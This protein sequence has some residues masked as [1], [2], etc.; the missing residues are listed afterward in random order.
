[1]LR[2]ELSYEELM[3]K[4]STLFK[5]LKNKIGDK[6][7]RYYVDSKIGYIVFYTKHI[8]IDFNALDINKHIHI[9][10]ESRIERCTSNINLLKK[11]YTLLKKHIIKAI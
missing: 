10:N 4:I 6:P 9:D 7:Y 5:I 11:Q 8:C 3:N 2:L 1:M